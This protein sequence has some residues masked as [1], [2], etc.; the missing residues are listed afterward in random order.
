MK[1]DVRGLSP[2]AK[3]RD[4]RGRSV[5]VLRCDSLSEERW[6]EA[7]AAKGKVVLADGGAAEGL[8]AGSARLE[9]AGACKD[10]WK[11]GRLHFFCC[12]RDDGE[13]VS[14]GAAEYLLRDSAELI[15]LPSLTRSRRDLDCATRAFEHLRA[16]PTAAA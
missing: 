5:C 15:I 2:K 1:T 6:R 13:R 9:W 16:R 12:E 14:R 4:A 11:L 3:G 7:G 10:A 8:A